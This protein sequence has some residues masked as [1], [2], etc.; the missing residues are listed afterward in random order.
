MTIKIASE[1]SILELE[2]LISY[3]KNAVKFM[4]LEQG[5]LAYPI[6][7]DKFVINN[8]DAIPEVSIGIDKYISLNLEFNSAEEEAYKPMLHYCKGTDLTKASTLPIN[9]FDI[10][11]FDD[12][13]S[14]IEAK[15]SIA[16]DQVIYVKSDDTY[17][18]CTIDLKAE[19]PYFTRYISYSVILSLEIEI[20]GDEG[21]ERL[22]FIFD[23]LMKVSSN[24][25]G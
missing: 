17:T 14:G 11:K 23:P 16:P 21:K 19:A 4:D 13:G 25:G 18:N 24:Q 22:Y 20:G 8:K 10:F 9:W 3:L 2:V 7:L 12:S 15:I 6:A 5:S 1:K